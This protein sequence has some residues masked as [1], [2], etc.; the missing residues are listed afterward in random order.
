MLDTK[1]HNKCRW[2]SEWGIDMASEKR[3]RKEATELISDNLEAER[4]PLSF[5]HKD[6]GEIIKDAP[7]AYVPRLWEKI[8]DLLNQSS[9]DNRG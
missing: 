8:E 2:M 5:N 3:M 7:I 4:V 1:G 9:D 6:G